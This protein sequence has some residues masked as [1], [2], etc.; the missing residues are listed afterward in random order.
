MCRHTNVDGDGKM[1]CRDLFLY[2]NRIICA[3]QSIIGG[4]C[5]YISIIILLYFVYYKIVK[6]AA[7][8]CSN[9]YC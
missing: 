7:G 4:L 1:S 3:I 8:K 6:T 5:M 9:T 2:S